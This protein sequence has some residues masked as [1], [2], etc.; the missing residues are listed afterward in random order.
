MKAPFAADG[1]HLVA[2]AK[3]FRQN[4]AVCHGLP[5]RPASAI[6]KGMFPRPPQL[7]ESGEDV[8][9]D[10]VGETYWKVKNGIRLTGMPGFV[11]SLSPRQLWEVSLLLHEG[12]HLPD[13]ARQALTS[14]N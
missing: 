11:G 12:D 4:C 13:P 10:P 14:G 9:D 2:G 8:A 5:Q 3:V 6:S 7:Y 1:A